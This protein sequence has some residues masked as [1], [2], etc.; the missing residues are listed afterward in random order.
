MFKFR[1]D[2]MDINDFDEMEDLEK[3]FDEVEEI[4]E[5]SDDDSFDYYC[6]FCDSRVSVDEVSCQHTIYYFETVNFL[7]FLDPNFQKLI[8]DIISSKVKKDGIDDGY[9]KFLFGSIGVTF[10]ENNKPTFNDI[11]NTIDIEESISY[12][13]P[14]LSIDTIEKFINEIK[15]FLPSFHIKFSGYTGGIE[16]TIGNY[17]GLASDEDIARLNERYNK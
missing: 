15:E 12:Y 6:K 11:Y 10:D 13:E 5:D 16:G 2:G 9:V 14:S 7:I 4:E 3:D 8:F 17:H 1:R